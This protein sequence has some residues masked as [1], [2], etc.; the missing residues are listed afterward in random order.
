MC[1]MCSCGCRVITFRLSDNDPTRLSE[2]YSTFTSTLNLMCLAHFNKII[3]KEEELVARQ[4]VI[5][6]NK[7]YQ[8]IFVRKVRKK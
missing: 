7:F 3:E 8:D 5:P 1:F 2:S 6:P 4:Q